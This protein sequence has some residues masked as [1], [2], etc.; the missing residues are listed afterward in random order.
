MKVKL[1]IVV[2]LICLVSGRASM[3]QEGQIRFRNLDVANGLSQGSAMAI[4]QDDRGFIWI[5]T[6]DGLNR[7]DAREFTV[8]RN[9]PG[10]SLSLSSNSITSLYND[11]QGRLWVGT[12][13]GLNRYDPNMD[14]FQQVLLGDERGRALNEGLVISFFEDREGR[15]WVCTSMG[16]YCIKKDECI[17]RLAFHAS[18]YPARNI[19]PR[20]VNAVFQ[21]SK[22]FY[23]IG[24]SQ[25]LIE[26]RLVEENSKMPTFEIMETYDTD[27]SH[28]LLSDHN[29]T[30]IN[31]VEKGLLWVGTKKGGIN[32]LNLQTGEVRFIKAD[33]QFSNGIASNDIRSI[34]KD[35]FGGFWVGTFRGLNHYSQEGKWSKYVA[36]EEASDALRHNSVK[37]IFQDSKGSIWIGTYY[38]GVHVFDL[39]ISWFNN[40]TYSPY[41]NSISHNVV[42]SIEETDKGNLW[43]GTEGGGLNFLD[44]NSGIFSQFIHQDDNP[45]SLSHNNVKSLYQDRSGN[46]WVGTYSGGLNLLKNGKSS[47]EHFMNQEEDSLSL[48]SDN[49]YAI[50]EDQQGNLWLGT[51]GGGVNM[52]GKGN[53]GKFVHYNTNKKGIYHL[54][55]REVRTLIVDTKDRVWVGTEDGLNLREREGDPFQVFHFEPNVQGSLSG[56]VVVSLLEDSR[57]R[58]WIG[59]F[60][61]GLNLY[62][63]ASRTFRNFT[64][65]DGLA[66]NNVFGILEDEKGILWLSTNNGLSRFDPETLGIKNYGPEDGLSGREFVMGGAKKLTNGQ[67]AFGSSNGFTLFHPDS[68]RQSSYPPPVVLTDFKLF[69]KSLKPDP[70]GVMAENVSLLKEIVL[71]HDQNIFS[72]DFAVLNYV[73]PEKN[74]YAFMLEGFDNQWNYVKNPTATYTNLNAGTYT[75]MAKGSNNDGVW[76]DVPARIVIRVL[77]PPWKTWWAFLIYGTVIF[78]A[79][80]YLMRFVQTRAK[81]E[82]D[83]Y[84]EHLENEQQ[85]ELHEL[86]L[87]FFTNISHEFR[88]P[89]TLIIGPLERLLQDGKTTGFQ[90]SLLRTIRGN[91]NRLLGLVNQ[92]MDFRKQESGNMQMKVSQKDLVQFLE[93]RLTFFIPYA[94][95]RNVALHFDKR[96]DS[97]LVYFDS[98]QLDKVVSNLL[99]NAFKY[100]PEEGKIVLRVDQEAFTSDFPKGAAVIEVEDNGEGIPSADLELIFDGFYQVSDQYTSTRGKENSSGIGLALTKSLVTMHKGSIHAFS[101][102]LNNVESGS[103]TCFKVKIPLGKDHLSKELICDENSTQEMKVFEPMELDT[104]DEV[105]MVEKENIDLP[106]NDP[107][108]YQIVVVEDNVE[109]REFMVQSLEHKYQVTAVENGRKGWEYIQ[110]ELPD[111]VVSDVMMPE[112]DGIEMTKLIKKDI[113]TD[114][115]PVLLLTARTSEDYMMKGLASGSMD[116]ITKPFHLD[117]LL[118]KIHNILE[119]RENFRKRFST[120]FLKKIS[121]QKEQSAEK[122]FLDKIIQIIQDNLSDEGFSVKVLCKE[123]GMSRPVLYRKLKQLTD[124]SVIELI[125]EVKMEKASQMLLE[126]GSTV[127][128]VAYSLGFSDP[129][130]FGKSFKNQFGKSPSKFMEE[131]KVKYINK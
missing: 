42:S 25:G 37:S 3:A 117:M 31:E 118:L 102:E 62:D 115:I 19:A 18:K 8:Y 48:S 28:S 127:S 99:S 58:I 108:R 73:I 89:L 24:T 54:S 46:L 49:V 39:D 63:E 81:L 70:D 83:L 51:F 76:S 78:V 95:Q 7:Y 52:M 43:I 26:G 96:V 56:D 36:S 131:N 110:K 98:E 123:I 91:A 38:G 71:R 4:A 10:D 126:E 14:R 65:E 29:I 23:W 35:K 104:L 22:G 33:A 50:D 66:G 128:D 109:L 94:A 100:T 1:K 84:V 106:E 97:L 86:K 57:H 92:L 69:N 61:T 116:Y 74:Q 107:L 47:F 82:H 80:Y 15:L 103:S 113:R 114:H 120:G 93:E 60:N 32:I 12:N 75:F 45:K 27:G 16:L 41:I 2:F 79:V 68:L 122:E 87:N 40:H 111:M 121:R 72:I 64:V 112:M 9:Q 119:S 129:K 11:S 30:C 21:D 124:K 53:W 130:Y 5:G 6:R 77:P 101:S 67:L 85:K 59:T 88:T 20:N 105:T 90:L 34:F 125:N 55:S 13:R 44:R 17:A